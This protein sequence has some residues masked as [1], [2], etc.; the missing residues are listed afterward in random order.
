MRS[1]IDSLWDNFGSPPRARSVVEDLVA[2]RKGAREDLL[3]TRLY[4]ICQFARSQPVMKHRKA[5]ARV[6]WKLGPEARSNLPPDHAVYAERYFSARPSKT[7]YGGDRRSGDRLLAS[8]VIRMAARLY[9]ELGERAEFTLRRDFYTFV[10]FVGELALGE[11]EPFTR[12]AIRLCWRK[13]KPEL[14]KPL[15][16]FEGRV[17]DAREGFR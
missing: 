17:F 13:L 3:R 8:Q 6:V 14:P 9:W 4:E 16:G 12:N 11:R 10:N 5:R 2:L 1:E 7:S 15:P